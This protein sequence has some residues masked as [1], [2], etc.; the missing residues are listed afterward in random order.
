MSETIRLTTP[1]TLEKVQKLRAG[2]RI[3][4]DGTIYTGRDAAHKRL[5]ALLDAGRPLPVDLHDRIIYFVG[6][7]PAPPGRPVG[8]AG[9]TTSGRMDAYSPRLLAE[10]GLR[11][12]IGK[13]DRNPAVIEAMKRY[14]G[15]YFAATGGA[16]ALIARC[17][18]SC[19]TVA[20]EDLGPEAM[21]EM[22][23][24]A[25][26]LV[27]AIDCQGNNLYRQSSIRSC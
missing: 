16:G 27:A 26:P 7:C 8:S 11:G 19:R 12:M 17:I 3:L 18:K 1:L 24:E 4:L 9:P 13:G 5:C 23:V 25:L 2:M 15:V 6:P 21:Y 14:G 20:F 22:Q 10:C